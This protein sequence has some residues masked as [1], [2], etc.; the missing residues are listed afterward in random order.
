MRDGLSPGLSCWIFLVFAFGV[1][2][3]GRSRY[4][5]RGR[6]LLDFFL[7]QTEGGRGILPPVSLPIRVIHRWGDPTAGVPIGITIGRGYR[8]TVLYGEGGVPFH[9]PRG[10]PF[11]R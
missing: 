10:V 2:S 5:L 3:S 7:S 8:F 1:G 4:R 6:G 11:H 9:R